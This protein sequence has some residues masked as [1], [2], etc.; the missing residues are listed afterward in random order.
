M[1]D[2]QKRIDDEEKSASMTQQNQKVSGEQ[3]ETYLINALNEEVDNIEFESRSKVG[4][5]LFQAIHFA[6]YEQLRSARLFKREWLEE[7]LNLAKIDID[8]F[9]LLSRQE[10]YRFKPI[11][12]AL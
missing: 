4:K 8:M 5:I 10:L 9:K 3:F 1:E 11:W 12:S 7:Y 2:S 6:K